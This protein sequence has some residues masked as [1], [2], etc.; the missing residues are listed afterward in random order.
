M[1]AIS[2][3]PANRAIETRAKITKDGKGEMNFP[4]LSDPGSATINAYGVYDPAYAGKE[5]DGIPHPA[6]YVL[7]KNRKVIWSRIE[8]DY[9]KRPTNEEIRTALTLVK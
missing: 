5:V 7:D 8:S 3:D 4:L 6:V 1:F 9:R 2:P